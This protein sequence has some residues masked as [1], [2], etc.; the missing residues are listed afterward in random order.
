M[1]STPR[2]VVS[3][4]LSLCAAAGVAAA[5][6]QHVHVHGGQPGHN[7]WAGCSRGVHY[8]RDGFR[9]IGRNTGTSVDSLRGH[10]RVKLK[11]G[12]VYAGFF[13]TNSLSGRRAPGRMR[14]ATST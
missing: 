3:C 2:L 4:L 10:G 6:R 9:E 8:R 12:L 14:R 13:G 7:R 1:T 11:R 5:P